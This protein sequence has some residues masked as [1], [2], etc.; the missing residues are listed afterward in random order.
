MSIIQE[1]LKKVGN[2]GES[3]TTAKE[4]KTITRPSSSKKLIRPSVYLFI[5]FLILAYFAFRQF[6]AISSGAAGGANYHA[7]L[8][9]IYKPVSSADAETTS[10]VQ[11]P[12]AVKKKSP[13][14]PGF[15]LSGVMQLV[16]GPRAIIN[17]VVVGVGDVVNGAKV[18]K[19]DKNGVVLKKRDSE[20]NLGMD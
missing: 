6:S 5:I 19:I 10:S 8:Q 18:L 15:I 7:L 13:S 14:F 11:K 16:D 3:K 12:G 20:I 1:A 2:A 9:S 17:D 4:P